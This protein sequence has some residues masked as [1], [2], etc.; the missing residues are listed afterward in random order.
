[1]QYKQ[2]QALLLPILNNPGYSTDEHYQAT[3][4]LSYVC[5]RLPDYTTT[6][7]FLDEAEQLAP[8]TTNSAVNKAQAEAQKAFVYWIDTYARAKAEDLMGRLARLNF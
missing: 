6:L 3:I 8:K 1:M 5:K 7:Q 2:S 4:L